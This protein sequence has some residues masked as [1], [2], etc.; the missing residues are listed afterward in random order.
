MP[1]RADLGPLFPHFTQLGEP[2]PV[3]WALWGQCPGI[4]G[5]LAGGL[6]SQ[7]GSPQGFSQRRA[8]GAPGRGRSSFAQDCEVGSFDF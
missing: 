1:L 8:R 2:W 3:G 4:W 5:W 7:L 6:R